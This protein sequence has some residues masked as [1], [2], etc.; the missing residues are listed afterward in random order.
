MTSKDGSNGLKNGFCWSDGLW[1][2]RKNFLTHHKILSVVVL[3][4]HYD[5]LGGVCLQIEVFKIFRIRTF[6]FSYRFLEG[7][8]GA[9]FQIWSWRLFDRL[10]HVHAFVFFPTYWD[11]FVAEGKPLWRH[12]WRHASDNRVLITARSPIYFISSAFSFDCARASWQPQRTCTDSRRRR[13]GRRRVWPSL[14]F[15]P[16]SAGLRSWWLLGRTAQARSSPVCACTW[17]QWIKKCG[18]Y[19]F[20]H[21]HPVT[22]TPARWHQ[23]IGGMCGPKF[24]SFFTCGCGRRWEACSVATSPIETR[25]GRGCWR[26]NGECTPVTPAGKETLCHHSHSYRLSCDNIFSGKNI[27]F[28]VFACCQKKCRQRLTHRIQAVALVNWIFV[29]R[30]Q[31]IESD[32]L[33]KTRFLLNRLDETVTWSRPL[34]IL[35]LE[36]NTFWNKKVR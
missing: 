21:R 13:G 34:Q 35:E 36:N 2:V 6:N 16:G 27:G 11:S 22:S 19:E 31:L 32:D 20:I 25:R 17:K 1:K 15:A 9:I 14:L 26:T 10:G 28:I 29:V 24:E 3:Q 30:L 5:Y 7:M 18:E 23:T 8:N 33:Q 12:R 4:S